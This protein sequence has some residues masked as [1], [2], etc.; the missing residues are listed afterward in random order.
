MFSIRKIRNTSV[1]GHGTRSVEAWECKAAIAAAETVVKELA[2]GD[3]WEGLDQYC[4][5]LEQVSNNLE[6]WLE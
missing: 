4:F 3:V 5:S 6:R 2:L 1:V